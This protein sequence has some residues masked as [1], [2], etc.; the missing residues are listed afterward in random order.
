MA[1]EIGVSAGFVTTSPTA[2]PNPTY[3]VGFSD[4][5]QSGKFTSP[6]GAS[7][8][9][10]IGFYNFNAS[11]DAQNMEFGIYEDDS[12][13]SRPGTLLYGTSQTSIS[14]GKGWKKITGLNIAISQSTSYWIAIQGDNNSSGLQSISADSFAGEFSEYKTTSITTLPSPWGVSDGDNNDFLVAAY[15][16]YETSSTTIQGLQSIIGVSS[17]TL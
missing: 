1:L 7:K 8:I 2:D 10:E 14:S 16:V 5:V 9:T 6:S 17:I 3:Q 15:A 13:N 11:A 4:S 12:I